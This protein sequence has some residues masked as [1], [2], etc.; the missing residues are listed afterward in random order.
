M[1]RHQLQKS[2]V[3]LDITAEL[4][5]NNSN[6]KTQREVLISQAFYMRPIGAAYT[7][8]F[9]I[10][11]KSKDDAKDAKDTAINMGY[12][13]VF[14]S[15]NLGSNRKLYPFVVN[16]SYTE[17]TIIGESSK[18]LYELFIPFI[19]AVKNNVIFVY[20]SLPVIS[21]Y[22]NDRLTAEAFK[23]AVNLFLSKADLSAFLSSHALDCWTVTVN[24]HAK[25]LKQLGS[26]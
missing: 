23:K 5:G 17:H 18:L 7:D 3:E 15:V 26:F 9:Y 12:I 4:T 1:N 2:L 25:H 14:S 24:V 6:I 21:F 11:C 20:S 8:S 22:F 13:N 16:V 19:D 10:F